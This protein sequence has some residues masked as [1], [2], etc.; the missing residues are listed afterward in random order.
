MLWVGEKKDDL[1]RMSIA[2]QK[3]VVTCWFMTNEGHKTRPTRVLNCVFILTSFRS[4]R[5]SNRL[6][7]CQ[8]WRGC[9]NSKKIQAWCTLTATNIIDLT[10]RE[11]N[12]EQPQRYLGA[13][14]TT[15]RLHRRRKN[16][17]GATY[18]IV[19]QWREPKLVLLFQNQGQSGN[20]WH[21]PHF[22]SKV[23]DGR[24]EMLRDG[25]LSYP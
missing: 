21:T 22:Q 15:P 16:L 8:H 3:N 20:C 12:P 11:S 9:N 13:L 2:T 1:L 4:H 7:W 25:L 17:L 14:P 10:H 23:I 6:F 18:E 24:M 19:T 5:K